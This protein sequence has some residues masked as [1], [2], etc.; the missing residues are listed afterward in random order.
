MKKLTYEA[1]LQ[2]QRR[3]VSRLLR[4][5][6]ITLQINAEKAESRAMGKTFSQFRNRTGHLRKSI[7]GSVQKID[8]DLAMVLRAGGSLGGADVFYAKYVEFGTRKGIR[9]RLFMGRS[10]AIQQVQVR[11]DLGPLL[12]ESLK[13]RTTNG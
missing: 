6:E 7:N 3:V 2:A 4:N 5:L 13:L 8:G 10:M 9:A 11:K 1:W 12:R